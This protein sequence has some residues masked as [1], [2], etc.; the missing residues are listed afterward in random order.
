MMRGKKGEKK[1]GE[2]DLIRWSL[3]KGLD[4]SWFHEQKN[5]SKGDSVCEKNLCC[6]VEDRGAM[7]EG[8]ERGL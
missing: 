8:Y 6:W 3:G 2:S 5:Q 1:E 4:S 7:E